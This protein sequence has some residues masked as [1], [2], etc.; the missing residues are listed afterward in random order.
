MEMT[1]DENDAVIVKATIE[2]AH[3]LGLK[4]IAEGV[5][6]QR[7]WD[8]LRT[9]NCDIAQGYFISRPISAEEFTNRIVSN[10][11]RECA[12]G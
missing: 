7:T 8:H 5:K 11:W 12:S 9:L 10:N 6:D 4:I 1:K 2:L 3:N